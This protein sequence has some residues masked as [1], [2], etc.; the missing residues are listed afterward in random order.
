MGSCFSDTSVPDAI[1]GD[2]DNNQSNFFLVKPA[3]M[4]SS[5][6]NVFNQEGQK[7]M[8]I[9]DESKWSDTHA[10]LTLENFVRDDDD[11]GETLATLT[12]DTL[13]LDFKAKV[14]ND[15]DDEDFLDL[16]NDLF[17]DD[18]SDDEQELECKTKFKCLRE[19]KIR[20]NG[21]EMKVVVRIKGKTNLTYSFSEDQGLLPE[22][23]EVTHKPKKVDYKLEA[24]GNPIHLEYE[25]GKWSQEKKREWKAPSL[26]TVT[27]SEP[28]ECEITTEAGASVPPASLLLLAYAIVAFFNPKKYE[29][30]LVDKAKEFGKEEMRK[31]RGE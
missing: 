5:H 16:V 2:P 1:L 7:W 4:F 21:L 8:M 20:A 22:P 3:G 26:F 15:D 29:P 27:S 19:G 30:M 9:R 10:T 28:G 12:V 14:E 31:R 6:F 17:S 11:H 24:N 13:D 25:N 18:G 23:T